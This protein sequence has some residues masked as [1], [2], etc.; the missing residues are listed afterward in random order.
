[1]PNVVKNTT[2]VKPTT[3]PKSSAQ[4]KS[5]LVPKLLGA[6]LG[7]VVVALL[8]LFRVELS[9]YFK[10]LRYTPSAEMSEIRD[11]LGLTSAGSRIFAATAP[12]LESR[13]DFNRDCESF[14]V[15]TAVLGCFTNDHVY[16][17]NIDS[18]ELAGIRESTT[19]HELLH[20]VWA[21][22]SGAEKNR[23]VPLLEEVYAENRD[24]LK[25]TLAAYSDAERLDE[26]YVRSATQIASLPAELETHFAK[27][28]S[29]RARIVEFYNAYITPF[30]ELNAEID[31]L[32][33][34]LESLRAT[35]DAKTAEYES[36]SAEFN[37]S[38]DEF[39]NCA[40]TAGCFASDYAFRT[41]RAELVATSDSLDA[42]YTELNSMIDDYNAKVEQ[43]NSNILRSNN[44]QNLINSN[45]EAK[46]LE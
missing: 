8:F 11:S 16:V 41:R 5:S 31:R 25:D 1:M 39:N 44:L 40:S 46:N 43:Y 3:P 9:D 24:S 37:R 10:G 13:E 23:L 29:S 26:L 20:A 22:L 21:R 4:P 14:D 12:T 45:S 35:I 2:L 27:Y 15:E 18:A 42:A 7:V 36:A 6:L 30:N 38:V 19:A 33:T 34:E 28:F 32:G 17:Y